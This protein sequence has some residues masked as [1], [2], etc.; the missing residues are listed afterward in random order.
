MNTINNNFSRTNV[1]SGI[2]AVEILAK[3]KQFVSGEHFN[4]LTLHKCLE[5]MYNNSFLR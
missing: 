4:T 5:N 1:K 2:N 3:S